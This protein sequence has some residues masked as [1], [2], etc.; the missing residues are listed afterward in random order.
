MKVQEAPIYQLAWKEAAEKRI[1]DMLGVRG[2]ETTP[3]VGVG[4][5][6]GGVDS[7]GSVPGKTVMQMV[8]KGPQV[9]PH[10]IWVCPHDTRGRQS[11]RFKLRKSKKTI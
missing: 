6:G 4:G 7:A 1:R 11:C 5:G 8:P 3:G 2:K 9:C 10:D